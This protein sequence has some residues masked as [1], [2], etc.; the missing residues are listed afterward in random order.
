MKQ[1]ITRIRNE[2]IVRDQ[3]ILDVSMF[4]NGTID[5]QLMSD[6]GKD[7]Y[8]K[9]RDIDFDAFITVESSGIAPAVFASFYANKPLI[10]IKK[11]MNQPTSSEISYVTCHSYTK[12][13]TFY[14][15]AHTKHLESKKLILIDD[16]LAQGN[17]VNA[18]RNLFTLTNTKLSG[19]GICIAKTFQNGYKSLKQDT[20]PFYCQARITSL[21]PF[22]IEETDSDLDL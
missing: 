13:H 18:V 15:T 6:I 17:V 10:V 1:L 12:N 2:S 16:F 3:E 20:I 22:L 4:F 11:M 14:L 9:F 5:P 7:L 21:N 8:M 19:V